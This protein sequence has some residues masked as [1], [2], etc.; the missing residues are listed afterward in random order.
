MHYLDQFITEAEERKVLS[1]EVVLEY[2]LAGSRMVDPKT[3][4]D[5]LVGQGQF[6]TKIGALFSEVN[7]L[8]ELVPLMRSKMNIVFQNL[9]TDLA[10][11]I[12]KMWNDY[13]Q[14]RGKA[15]FKAWS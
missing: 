5:D 10:K 3:G 12:I 8:Q 4:K 9:D 14:Q 13:A 6:L 7:T 2:E 1:G 15:V 11:K